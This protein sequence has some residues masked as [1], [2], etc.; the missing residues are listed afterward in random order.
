MEDD[1][2]DYSASN[3]YTEEDVKPQVPKVQKSVLLQYKS[4]EVKP[5]PRIHKC[6]SATCDKMFSKPSYAKHHHDTV[7]W[8]LIWMKKLGSV[9]E[10]HLDPWGFKNEVAE[11]HFSVEKAPPYMLNVVWNIR[12]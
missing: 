8:G 7:R 2:I 10:T 11:F 3:E 4:G 9:N 12:L 6:P 1:Y 5:K